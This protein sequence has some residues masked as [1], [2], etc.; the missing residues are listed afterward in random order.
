MPAWSPAH[1]DGCLAMRIL[2]RSNTKEKF[3]VNVNEQEFKGSNEDDNTVGTCLDLRRIWSLLW[4][5]KE[6]RSRVTA[7]LG[8]YYYCDRPW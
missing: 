4:Q 8:S 3:T 5:S 2:E 6:I 7:K 1:M